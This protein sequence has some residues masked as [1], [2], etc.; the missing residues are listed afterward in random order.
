MYFAFS[1]TEM[2]DCGIEL[3]ETHDE[4]EYQKMHNSTCYI[5]WDS[6]SNTCTI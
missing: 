3:S 4:E 6:L 1:I 5:L 2:H